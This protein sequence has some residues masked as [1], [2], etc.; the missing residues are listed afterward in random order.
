[1]K[2]DLEYYMSLDYPVE[3]RRIPESD[4][5]GYIATIPSLGSYAFV[6]DGET[7]EE[8]YANLQETKRALFD[9]YLAQGLEIPEPPEDDVSAYSGRFVARLPR[10]LHRD[11]A[12]AAEANGISLNQYIVYA[13]TRFRY[14]CG[15]STR[16]E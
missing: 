1:M 7:P 4:G 16:Q 2:K 6:G 13:L 3:I 8:A 15:H 10:E 9:E 14:S 5:G 11:L 12:D